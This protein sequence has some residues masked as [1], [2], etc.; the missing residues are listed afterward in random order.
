MKFS[1]LVS[2]S[3]RKNRKRYFQSHSNFRRTMMSSPLSK[4]LQLKY[5]VKSLPIRK[6]D[7]VKIIRGNMKGKI[8][9]VIQCHRKNFS[10]YIEDI[11]CFKT[12]KSLSYVPISSS[13]VVITNLTLTNE[14]KLSFLKKE[15][16]KNNI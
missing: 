13:N 5:N 16:T 15:E 7:E 6:D 1:S 3:R 14:R 2:S 8:G 10:I 11:T 4:N 12:G 9:K